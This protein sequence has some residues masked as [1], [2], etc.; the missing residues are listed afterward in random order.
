[1]APELG[2]APRTSMRR[3]SRGVEREERTVVVPCRL[4]EVGRSSRSQRISVQLPSSDT[5]QA[6]TSAFGVPAAG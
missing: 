1:V 2:S 4:G 3:W 5:I 6:V